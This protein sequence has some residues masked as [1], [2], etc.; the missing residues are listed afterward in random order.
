MDCTSCMH[1]PHL[2]HLLV[3]LFSIPFPEFQHIQTNIVCDTCHISK[4]HRLPFHSTHHLSTHPFDLIHVDIWGPYKH[5]AIDGSSYF[6]TLVENHSRCTWIY[7]L[8]S[9][10][11]V[12]L[13]LKSF[14]AYVQNHFHTT[15]KS[16]RSD[17][18]QEFLSKECSSLFK[19]LGIVHQLTVCYTP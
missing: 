5:T 16:L 19:H 14:F 10:T 2:Q 4:F 8:S 3:H 17:N 7:L 15:V 6:L 13:I 1:H 11:Q 12:P 9:K 18:G